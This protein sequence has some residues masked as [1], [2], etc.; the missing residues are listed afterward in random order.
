LQSAVQTLKL[1]CIAKTTRLGYD[2]KGQIT[3]RKAEEAESAWKALKTDEAIVEALVPFDQEISVITARRADGQMR[4]Y[5]PVENRHKNAI[6]D[7]THVP[8]NI[9]EDVRKQAI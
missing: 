3:I 6:L 2:G 5:P 4:S 7:E 1:P 8:A 9:N